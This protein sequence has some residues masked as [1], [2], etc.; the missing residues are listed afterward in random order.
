[1]LA[2][3]SLQVLL[4]QDSLSS[5]SLD[6]MSEFG[7]VMEAGSALLMSCFVERLLFLVYS[8]IVKLS[9][10]LMLCFMLLAPEFKS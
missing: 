2:E 5:K 10:S 9:L 3:L 8:L 1:M 6:Y 4:K 7:P